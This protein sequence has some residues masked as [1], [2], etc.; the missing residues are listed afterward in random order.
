M[1]AT[2]QAFIAFAEPDIVPTDEPA[3]VIL[4]RLHQSATAEVVERLAEHIH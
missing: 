3:T 2:G 4:E 1:L